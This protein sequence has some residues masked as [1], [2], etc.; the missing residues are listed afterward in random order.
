MLGVELQRERLHEELKSNRMRLERTET[1]TDY[2]INY[3]RA[4]CD[5]RRFVKLI[6]KCCSKET[7][8]ELDFDVS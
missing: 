4:N 8:A 3:T 6:E 2:L 1:I 7:F 5:P